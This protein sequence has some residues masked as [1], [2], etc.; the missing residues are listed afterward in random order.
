MSEPRT[1]PVQE[2][3]PFKELLAGWCGKPWKPTRSIGNF[4]WCPHCHASQHTHDIG[5]ARAAVDARHAEEIAKILDVH[6][7]ELTEL[8]ASYQAS[9]RE[10][11]TLREQRA[12][13]QQAAREVCP[14][15]DTEDGEAPY[16]CVGEEGTPIIEADDIAG[17]I[18]Q[19]SD[20][21]L[22]AQKRYERAE[23]QLAV[24]SS[25]STPAP[26]TERR[27]L[28]KQGR[29]YGQELKATIEH[30]R[31]VIAI[32]VQTLAHATA[33]ADWANP[34]DEDADDYIRTFA[35]EDASQFAEDVV[36][37]MLD[38]RE[39]GS[40]PL[41]DFID[42]MAEAAINDGSLGLHEDDQKIKHGTFAPC[43][44]WA[45]EPKP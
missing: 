35:I 5:V 9:Q 37:A 34:F 44:T 3:D 43:E 33:Y 6:H 45:E 7:A 16:V 26:Q 11:T 31:L 8:H 40:T 36:S 18:R 13:V 23:A 15:E 17:V 14:A 12:A 19:M 25:A 39:D 2:D 21:W 42:K 27:P 29:Y 28:K 24:L 10:N 41:S 4:L 30:G 1:E 38:E 22:K 32:G 20:L